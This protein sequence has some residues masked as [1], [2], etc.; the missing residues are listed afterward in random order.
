MMG[1]RSGSLR[2]LDKNGTVFY[3]VYSKESV[4]GASGDSKASVGVMLN[5]DNGS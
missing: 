1:R 3:C 2:V 5:K 4:D